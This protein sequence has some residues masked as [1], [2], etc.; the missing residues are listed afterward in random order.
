MGFDGGAKF[1][2]GK[3]LAALSMSYLEG[4][5]HSLSNLERKLLFSIL[6]HFTQVQEGYL[7]KSTQSARHIDTLQPLR[8]HT[9]CCVSSAWKLR[10]SANCMRAGLSMDSKCYWSATLQEAVEWEQPT[11]GNCPGKYFS[12]S[13]WAF[14]NKYETKGFDLEV[15]T[16]HSTSMLAFCSRRI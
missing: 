1:G 14:M 6:S 10:S 8:C 13:I 2:A 11:V 4:G 16:T 3:Q 9:L 15:G 7:P 12:S 5:A